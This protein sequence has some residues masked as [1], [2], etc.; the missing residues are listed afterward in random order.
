MCNANKRFLGCLALFHTRFTAL[1]LKL[2]TCDLYRGIFYPDLSFKMGIHFRQ[3]CTV[4]RRVVG[5]TDK[6]KCRTLYS[7][8]V[9]ALEGTSVTGF[10]DSRQTVSYSCAS[11]VMGENDTTT[12]EL[13]IFQTHNRIHLVLTACWLVYVQLCS[14]VYDLY[15]LLDLQPDF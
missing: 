9:P 2:L 12:C 3:N 14:V 5:D 6:T 1:V 11:V 8:F 4:S 13:K 10:E 15:D 7:P